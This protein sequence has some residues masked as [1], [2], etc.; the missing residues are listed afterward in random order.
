MLRPEFLLWQRLRPKVNKDFNFR[1][2]TPLLGRYIADFYVSK[3]KLRVVF[4]IDGMIHE[5]HQKSDAIRDELFRRAGIAVV[6]ISARRVL[7]DPDGVADL[8]RM[9]CLG[10]IKVQDL[11]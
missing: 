2:Q 4:E 1:R 11:E 7:A 8:I 6:R 9:I 10:E 5:L 3:G